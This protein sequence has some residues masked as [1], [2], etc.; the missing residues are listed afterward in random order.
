MKQTVPVMI[1]KKKKKNKT[2]KDYKLNVSPSHLIRDNL[3]WQFILHFISLNCLI[4]TKF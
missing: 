3:Q 2:S 4:K 1:K